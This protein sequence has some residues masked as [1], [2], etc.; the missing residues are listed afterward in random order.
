MWRFF[1]FQER[2][3]SI[4]CM[5]VDTKETLI[6]RSW[7]QS[8]GR[9]TKL[10]SNG[11]FGVTEYN[12]FFNLSASYLLPLTC[13]KSQYDLTDEIK[14]WTWLIYNVW[15]ALL[16]ETTCT[17]YCGGTR[18]KLSETTEEFRWK[19][20]QWQNWL[21]SREILAEWNRSQKIF[22][23]LTDGITSDRY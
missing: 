17:P 12:V 5:A 18:L 8:W 7:S 13:T 22:S 21:S 10:Q 1:S 16:F 19:N 15:M 23:K 20:Y 14:R 11:R 4:W 6:M 3:F 2:V 9:K